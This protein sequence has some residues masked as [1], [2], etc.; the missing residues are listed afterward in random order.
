ME[1]KLISVF[2]GILVVHW[3]DDIEVRSK[4]SSLYKLNALKI[5]ASW[6]AGFFTA[7]VPEKLPYVCASLRTEFPYVNNG[8]PSW[9]INLNSNFYHTSIQVPEID[10]ANVGD[11]ESGEKR[12]NTRL[13]VRA[14]YLPS[15]FTMPIQSQCR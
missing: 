11:L 8:Y 14:L 12:V 15:Q 1:V 4:C 6:K 5:A 9:H 2:K 3:R 10:V 7:L 13:G